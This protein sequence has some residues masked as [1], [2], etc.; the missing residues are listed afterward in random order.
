MAGGKADP[1]FMF[2]LRDSGPGYLSLSCYC[3]SPLLALL[4]IKVTEN[5]SC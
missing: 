1:I 2:S 5:T 3:I 4:K